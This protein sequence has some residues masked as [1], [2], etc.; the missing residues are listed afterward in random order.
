MRGSA[1]PE[2]RPGSLARKPTNTPLCL[3]QG[4]K[5][6][7]GGESEGKVKGIERICVIGREAHGMLEG[8]SSCKM[9]KRGGL[10]LGRESIGGGARQPGLSLPRGPQRS[11]V[12]QVASLGVE[13]E[14]L[15][16]NKKG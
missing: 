1:R 11:Q 15:S 10:V 6:K 2:T 7:I 14:G 8:K 13:G 12:F 9:G 3:P 16:S 5:E 4:G